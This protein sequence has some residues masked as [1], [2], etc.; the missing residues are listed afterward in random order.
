ML[1]HRAVIERLYELDRAIKDY[2]FQDLLDS[3]N[4]LSTQNLCLS[5]LWCYNRLSERK[6]ARVRGE[7]LSLKS[8]LFRFKCICILAQF[9]RAGG[10]SKFVLKVHFS[11]IL[12]KPLFL[13]YVEYFRP[14]AYQELKVQSALAFLYDYIILYK[15]FVFCFACIPSFSYTT[16]L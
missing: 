9:S 2:T 15:W 11:K 13:N 8:K 7:G 12:C 16:S 4:N 10:N 3:E 5:L 6:H 14:Q 1:Y